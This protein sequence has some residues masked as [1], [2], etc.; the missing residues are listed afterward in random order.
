MPSFLGFP[1]MTSLY[2]SVKARA[3][4]VKGFGVEFQGR[5]LPPS[6]SCGRTQTSSSMQTSGKQLCMHWLPQRTGA[7]FATALK[8]LPIPI[9][10]WSPP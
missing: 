5:I 10:F 6:L 3:F 9:N 4:R 2:K 1:V 7:K 8:T